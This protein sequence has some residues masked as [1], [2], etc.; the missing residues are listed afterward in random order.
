MSAAT[1][2]RRIG[3]P[4][5]HHAS[6]NSQAQSITLTSMPSD[7]IVDI[8]SSATTFQALQSLLQ[9]SGHSAKVASVFTHNKPEIYT[10]IASRQFHPLPDALEAASMEQLLPP[11]K[12]LDD[13]DD[14]T[15]PLELL[16][17]REGN[18]KPLQVRDK[19][20]LCMDERIQTLMMNDEVVQE[21]EKLF[22][23]RFCSAF[24]L[25]G[26]EKVVFRR[27]LYRIWAFCNGVP[28]FGSR[29]VFDHDEVKMQYWETRFLWRY[30]AV[31]IC[32]IGKVYAFLVGLILECCRK[33]HHQEYFEN[34]RYSG[35]EEYLSDVIGYHMSKGP[36]AVLELFQFACQETKPKKLSRALAWG[37]V[38]YQRFLIGDLEY[39]WYLKYPDIRFD[40]IIRKSF[41]DVAGAVE[42]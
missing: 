26:A 18:N 19:G 31:E 25:S 11:P 30:S 6:H 28:R 14:P 41:R 17:Y 12:D 3:P 16:P 36:Q 1:A 32:E 4:R 29:C 38:G 34:E 23:L 2:V 37:A 8:L 22:E 20:S 33:C 21:L 27:A 13:Y 24:K 5:K 15:T 7:M 39:V 10:S 35:D 42:D 40:S 9:R